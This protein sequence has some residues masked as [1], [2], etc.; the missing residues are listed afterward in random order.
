MPAA[1]MSDL[2]DVSDGSGLWSAPTTLRALIG[3]QLRR[4]REAQGVSREE[5][6]FLIRGS[7]SKISRMEAGR[8]GF[9]ARDVADLLTLYGVTDDGARA[10]LLALV[11]QA[12]APSWW[13]EYREAIP[14]WFEPFLGLEQ[15]ACL[16]RA[17]EV[18]LVPGLLQTEDYARA[19]ITQ[20]AES[21][22]SHSVEQRVALR[23]RRQ[24]VLTRDDPARLWV[25]LDEAALHR[26]VA[27]EAIMRAQW[28]HLT[29]MSELPHVTIQVLPFTSSAC[30]G[31][32]GPVTILRFP[33]QQL[34]DVVYI[35]QLT[36]AQYLTKSADVLPHH[37][38]MDELGLAALPPERTA[39]LLRELAAAK[40]G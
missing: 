23:M 17:Y 37:A 31:G 9:K 25:V 28:E 35:E 6:A 36:T 15:D 4:L 16:I 13:Q 7:N 5:A 30:A 2:N 38:L 32:L 21:A 24:R 3:A 12:N 14:D 11:E 22:G 1:D 40:T 29:K 34:P 33:Q 8:T 19:V 10:S 18:Q 39:G 27:G 20:G 26:R